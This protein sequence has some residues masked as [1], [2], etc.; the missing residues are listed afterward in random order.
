MTKYGSILAYT[1]RSPIP[2]CGWDGVRPA[3][4]SLWSPFSGVLMK[5]KKGVFPWE[6]G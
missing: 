4:S 1:I 3:W 6:R 2:V 5:K